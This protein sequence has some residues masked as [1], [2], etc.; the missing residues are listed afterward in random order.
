[1]AAGEQNIQGEDQQKL[2][3]YAC[4]FIQTL[5]NLKLYAVLPLKRTI[6]FITVEE[7]ITDTIINMW[8]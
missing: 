5:I 4:F 6:E 7:V 8:Y 1:V 3:V 2:D